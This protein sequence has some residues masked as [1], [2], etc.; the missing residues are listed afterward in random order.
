M[1]AV[2]YATITATITAVIA[3]VTQLI[4]ELIH[5]DPNAV[6]SKSEDISK[7]QAGLGCIQMRK[8]RIKEI[9]F[10]IFIW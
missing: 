3:I 1:S 4:V 9:H 6:K 7:E 8:A 2:I 10:L 5:A